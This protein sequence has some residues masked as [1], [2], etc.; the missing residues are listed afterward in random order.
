M[1]PQWV[2][3]RYETRNGKPT[4]V[5]YQANGK[6]AKSDDSRTWSA[7]DEVAHAWAKSK[8]R[9]Q[10]I[11]FVFTETD[12]FAGID[13]DACIDKT[14]AVKP[15]ARPILEPFADTY[16]EVSPSGR[17]V[18]VWVKASLDGPGR[19]S[20]HQDGAI[21]IYDRGRF[22][23]TTGNVLNGAPLR[24]AD[25]Q[26][27]VRKLYALISKFGGQPKRRKADLTQRETIAEGQRYHFLQSAA[28]QYRAG[29]LDREAIY[30]AL[31]AMNN[32]RCVPAKNDSVVRELADWAATLAPGT[33]QDDE[34]AVSVKELADAVTVLDRFAKN[35]GGRLYVFRDGCYRPSGESF[36]KQRVKT[37]LNDWGKGGK[38][39]TRKATET[40]EYIRVD[41]PELRDVPSVEIINVANGLLNVCTH[42][43]APHSPEF[44][45]PIQLPVAFDPGARCPAWDTFVSEVF[46]ED[47]E[48]IAWEIPAWLMTPDTSIQKAILLTGEG[49]NGKSTYLRAVVAFIG[50]HNTA[51]VSLHKLEQDR[52]AA[53]R[54]LGK[55]ANV[56]PDLPTAHLAGT[57]MFKA[58]T[59]GDVVNAEFKY[60]DSFEFV[61]FAKLV[62][63]ANQPPRSDD[64]THG[65]FRRWQVVP[66]TRT[67]E[68]GAPGTV[69][70]EALD[71][72]LSAPEELSGALNKALAALAQIKKSGFTQSESMRKAWEEFRT[73]TDPLSVW[74][75]RYTVDA[76]AAVVPKADLLRAYSQACEAS[77]RA[78]MTRTGFGRALR[79]ARPDVRDT[80]RTMGDRVTD[81][82]T[83]IGFKVPDHDGGNP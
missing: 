26:A 7:I 70:R 75:D 17:G 2:L 64:A 39:T 62:F 66:F 25:H 53:S 48:A 11:G 59:G 15:W 8:A 71:A 42:K 22:F 20:P 56:C 46:P 79:R 49:A 83:G 54:L 21:E 16:Q 81:C 45:S 1:C 60:G 57:S 23:T 19:R 80:Q 37:L 12:P 55:L 78:P 29:G 36:I 27:E 10:G 72:R 31:A 6:R 63:S 77:G 43:L 41:A 32:K 33:H 73:A 44:L 14:G 65:F 35:P 18:K 69:P 40:C 3:W 47:S 24:V 28:A 67:F 4:K 58:L 76:P 9:Y 34:A 52:F 30:A 5:P 74:L 68:D 82:Y 38:W 13:L 50:K 51:A 61:P